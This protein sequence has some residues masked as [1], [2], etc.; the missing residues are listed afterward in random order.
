MKTTINGRDTGD[1]KDNCDNAEGDKK[2]IF[3]LS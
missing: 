3:Y 2:L 1:K